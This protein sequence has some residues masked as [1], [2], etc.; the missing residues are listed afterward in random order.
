MSFLRRWFTNS[1]ALINSTIC[2]NPLR[3]FDNWSVHS[4]SHIEFKFKFAFLFSR[5]LL[6][7]KEEVAG[8]AA[9]LYHFFLC[10]TGTYINCGLI[11]TY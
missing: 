8:Y 5:V 6:S 2:E 4:T 7:L 3:K 10:K 1:L 11:K 9:T